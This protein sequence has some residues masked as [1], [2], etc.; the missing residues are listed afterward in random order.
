MAYGRS[1]RAALV[2]GAGCVGGAA[3]AVER[4]DAAMTDEVEKRRGKRVS[5]LAL[6]RK[7]AGMLY[8]IWNEARDQAQS[9]RSD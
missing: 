7:P 2:F 1:G 8:A 3:R 4:S 6:A 5:V 9:D